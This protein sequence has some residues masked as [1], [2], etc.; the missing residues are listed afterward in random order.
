M[1]TYHRNSEWRKKNL[2][3]AALFVG[4]SK[5]P[6]NEIT[7]RWFKEPKKIEINYFS[8]VCT[9]NFEVI[10][11]VADLIAKC[12]L[13]NMVQ[14]N[15]F[16]GC[17]YCNIEDVTIS[18]PHSY[19]RFNQSFEIRRPELN[20]RYVDIA[21]ALIASA[22]PSNVCGVKGKSA[23]FG[24]VKNLP[25]SAGINYMHCVLLGCFKEILNFLWR[26]LSTQ[27]KIIVSKEVQDTGAPLG[28]VEHGRNLRDLFHIGHFKASEFFNYLLFVSPIIFKDRLAEFLYDNLLCLVFGI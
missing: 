2:C 28:V 21:E 18:R 19:Y 13:L 4:L 16:Y 23:F 20:D 5:P 1:P 3:L 7:P 26:G 17:N 27:E 22:S 15:G 11:I 25:L 9:V 24:L 14:Q 12:S 10:G 8:S 6:W